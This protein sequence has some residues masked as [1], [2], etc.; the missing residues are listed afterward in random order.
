MPVFLH[1][2][3]LIFH[4]MDLYIT[5]EVAE[6]EVVIVVPIIILLEDKVIKD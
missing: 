5:Q 1:F 6:V 3:D 4:L 2:N